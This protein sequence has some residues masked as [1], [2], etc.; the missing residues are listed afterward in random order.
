VRTLGRLKIG[1]RSFE[2][3]ADCRTFDAH[4]LRKPSPQPRL[5]GSGATTPAGKMHGRRSLWWLPRAVLKMVAVAL[6][7]REHLPQCDCLQ[8][9]AA[10]LVHGLAKAATRERTTSED[11]ASALEQGSEVG[12]PAHGKAPPFP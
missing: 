12:S 9:W 5:V 8:E 2:L 6:E 3:K 7:P 11:V 4:T 1:F 10:S